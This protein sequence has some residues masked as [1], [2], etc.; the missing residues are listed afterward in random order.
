[1]ENWLEQ[2]TE[3]EV[4]STTAHLTSL[5]RSIRSS[6]LLVQ[7]MV[8][9]QE[10]FVQLIAAQ[11]ATDVSS[12]DGANIRRL[13]ESQVHAALQT[14]GMADI[15]TEAQRLQ[16]AMAPKEKLPKRKKQPQWSGE[17]IA[18]QERLLASSKEKMLGTL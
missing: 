8:Q 11:L 9:C 10:R 6:P 1:M 2:L 7:A 4:S 17:E 5:C 13:G 14:L 12:R 3:V 16:Q 18:E 15:L